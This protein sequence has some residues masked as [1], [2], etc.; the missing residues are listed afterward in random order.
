MIKKGGKNPYDKE[1]KIGYV[2]PINGL[3]HVK[4]QQLID[5]YAI[6]M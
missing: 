5:T 2:V 4:L 3:N 1:Q 6:R